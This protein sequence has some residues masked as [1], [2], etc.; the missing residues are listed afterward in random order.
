MRKIASPFRGTARALS[1]AIERDAVQLHAMVDEAEAELF[2][3][4]LLQRFEFVVDELE[5]C[6]FRR[7]S[8]GRGGFQTASKRD[9]PSPNSWRSRIPASSNSRTV[10]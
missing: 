2:G 9:R 8:D 6:R 1:V 5:T 7:R 10:R 3:D 4:A